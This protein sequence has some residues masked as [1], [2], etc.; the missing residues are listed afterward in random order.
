MTTA[1]AAIAWMHT[2]GGYPDPTIDVIYRTVYEGARRSG[3]TTI[4]HKRPLDAE[5][6]NRIC[7]KSMGNRQVMLLSDLCTDLS[8][9]PGF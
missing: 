9:S 6:I 4:T 5:M 1:H 3:A 7:Q 2:S 8:H